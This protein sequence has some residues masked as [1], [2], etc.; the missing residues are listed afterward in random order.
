MFSYILELFVGAKRTTI[1]LLDYDVWKDSA[2]PEVLILAFAITCLHQHQVAHAGS[3]TWKQRDAIL[4][5]CGLYIYKRH[6]GGAPKT[7][8]MCCTK[9]WAMEDSDMNCIVR[10]L[11]IETQNNYRKRIRDLELLCAVHSPPHT[12][13]HHQVTNINLLLSRLL[14]VT[15]QLPSMRAR[16]DKRWNLGFCICCQ[17]MV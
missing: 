4:D 15:V 8:S 10:L 12:H 5:F 2:P 6:P 3:Y 9:V 17:V 7:S 1:T 13:H 16:S 14:K 11:S